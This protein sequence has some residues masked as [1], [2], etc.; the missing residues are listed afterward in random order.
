MLT[1]SSVQETYKFLHSAAFSY[2]VGSFVAALLSFTL[3]VVLTNSL[4]ESDYG[5]LVVLDSAYLIFLSIITFGIPFIQVHFF[6]RSP[7]ELSIVVKVVASISLLAIAILGA[8]V[9]FTSLRESFGSVL[10]DNLFLFLGV[11]AFGMVISITLAMLQSGQ[12]VG[13]YLALQSASALGVTVFTIGAV[14][15][16]SITSL[17]KGYGY[18]T[19][20]VILSLVIFYRY[21]GPLISTRFF[22][23][24]VAKDVVRFSLPLLPHSIAS[25]LYFNLDRFMLAA[26]GS[27]QEVAVYAVGIQLALGMSLLQDALGRA[28]TPVIL[29][30]LSEVRAMTD[31]YE[32][33]TRNKVKEQVRIAVVLMLAGLIF[34]LVCAQI[35]LTYFF[36]EAYKSA[37]TITMVLSI[38]FVF[39]GLYKVF[40]P[41][42]MYYERTILISCLSVFVLLCN[43]VANFLLIPVFGMM[44]AALATT[45]GMFLQ[46]LLVLVACLRHGYLTE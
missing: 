29:S 41:F 33:F 44:G 18:L 25:L 10:Y 11:L 38:G 6:K 4:N 45:V 24:S 21:F 27:L 17:A 22:S 28:W 30:H 32:S 26:L 1:A 15:F 3:T 5:S 23:W 43:A 36:P 20:G 31:D 14:Y 34:T 16:A 46:F 42:L 9:F 39:L 40:V 35:A 13:R 37:I 19:S 2:A 7:D 8:V 12:Q